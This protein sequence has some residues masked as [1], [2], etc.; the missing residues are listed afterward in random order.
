ML[1]SFAILLLAASLSLASNTAHL[2]GAKTCALCHKEIAATQ[3]QTAMATTWQELSTSWLP[4]PFNASVAD[5]LAYRI[6]RSGKSFTYS[7]SKTELPVNILMGGRRHGIGFLVP[8]EQIDGLP[9]ARKV[10]IQARY[11][12]SPEQNKLLLAPGCSP[13]KPQALEPALGLALSPT[14]EARCLAC[15]GQTTAGVHCESCH[16]PGSDHLVAISRGNPKQGIVNPKSSMEVCAKCHVGL[17][18]FADPSAED[19]LVANQVEAI[20]RSE[21]FIQSRKALSCT[22][23]HNPHRDAQA[24]EK[25]CLGCHSASIA[26]HAA[27]CPVNAKTGCI[28]CHMPSVEMGPLHL[29]DHLIRVH[30]EQNVPIPPVERMK[31]QVTPVSAYLRVISAKSSET[32]ATARERIIHG[33]SF[34]QVARELSIDPSA[35]IGGYIGR[36]SWPQFANLDYGEIS[37]VTEVDQKFLV[38]QRLPRDFR[39]SAEQLQ[40]EAEKLTGAAAIQKS[41]QALM[42]YPE[43]LRAINYIGITFATNGNSKKAAEVLKTAAKL[44]PEDAKTEFALASVL[45]NLGNNTEA[46]TA[47]QRVIALEPDF[48]AAYLKLGMMYYASEDWARAIDRFRQ[49]LLIDPMQ[50]ELNDDLG[51][52]LK[53]HGD[54]SAGEQATN[55]ARKLEMTGDH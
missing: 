48:T 55:L 54:A 13:G 11:A 24:D 28:G 20:Q 21:C 16:G 19:L 34:Y 31:T 41:Q 42:I 30:P 18:R 44:Y 32:A 9:L 46:R 25:P 23:C 1:R 4:E 5:D 33:E 3:E 40:N 50:A 15:H 6:Q 29:V 51:L 2:V 12:W 45:E 43:F 26:S 52:A 8:L 17:T 53:K 37:P 39:W 38:V 10:L 27:I 35:P 14:F 7:V 22:T 36:K 47:Y 49:G